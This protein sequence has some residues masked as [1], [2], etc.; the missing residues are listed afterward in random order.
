MINSNLA[1]LHF[2]AL[3]IFNRKF[4]M[5]KSHKINIR[6]Y[7]YV[8]HVII[9]EYL[10]QSKNILNGT[11]YIQKKVAAGSG[12]TQGFCVRGFLIQKKTCDSVEIGT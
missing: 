12:V 5:F 2:S 1:M 11:K 6:I 8:A 7:F 9:K 4:L 3:H 10:G